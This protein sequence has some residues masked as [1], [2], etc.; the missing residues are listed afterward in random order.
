MKSNL[1]TKCSS[2]KGRDLVNTRIQPSHL[3]FRV[4]LQEDKTKDNE[5][6]HVGENVDY[7]AIG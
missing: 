5:T 6:K 2:Y 4:R 1:L 7:I 3:Q